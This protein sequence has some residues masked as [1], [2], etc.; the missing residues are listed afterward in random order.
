MVHS[1]DHIEHLSLRVDHFHHILIGGDQLTVARIQG[2][3]RV[4]NNSESGRACLEDLY[5]VVE[6]WHT[7][8]CYLK[9]S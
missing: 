2:A 7:K 6:D 8:M 5:P 9:V 3:Q 1:E 4:R